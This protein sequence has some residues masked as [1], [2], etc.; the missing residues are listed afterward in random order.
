LKAISNL[1][2]FDTVSLDLHEQPSSITVELLAY[3]GLSMFLVP[4]VGHYD[5][6]ACLSIIVVGDKVLIIVVNCKVQNLQVKKSLR[7]K[8]ACTTS[9]ASTEDKP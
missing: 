1:A 9:T 3:L 2:V 4:A 8:E 7:F 6:I 5:F